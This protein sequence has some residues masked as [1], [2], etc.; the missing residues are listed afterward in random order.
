MSFHL[1]I[2]HVEIV[3]VFLSKF[4]LALE[5]ALL[6]SSFFNQRYVLIVL[7]AVKIPIKVLFL[8]FL[9]YH[10]V[11]SAASLEE[12]N[13]PNRLFFCLIFLQHLV[14]KLMLRICFHSFC[15]NRAF[16]K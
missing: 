16:R 6:L 12:T 13:L 2:F 8:L 3:D 14:L 9:R 5:L 15:P 10:I 4:Y 1:L 7:L 11:L